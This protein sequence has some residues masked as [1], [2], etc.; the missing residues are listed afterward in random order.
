MEKFWHCCEYNNIT[1]VS[2]K[3]ELLDE[4]YACI[5]LEKVVSRSSDIKP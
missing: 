1:K 5:E 2:I 4:G 3:G